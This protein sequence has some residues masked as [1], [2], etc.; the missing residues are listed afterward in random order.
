MK[1]RLFFPGFLTII[2]MTELI[3]PGFL[4]AAVEN[5]FSDD[6]NGTFFIDLS[7]TSAQIQNGRISLSGNSF[8][9]Q[10][11]SGVVLFTRDP[12]IEVFLSTNDSKI[13]PETRIIYY[14]STDEGRTWLQ[15]EPG[16][17][18]QFSTPGS[19]LK[20]KAVLSRQQSGVGSPFIESI[21]LIARSDSEILKRSRDQQR[22]SDLERV[23]TALE[24]FRTDWKTYPQVDAQS[25]EFRW[26]QLEQILTRQGFDGVSYIFNFPQDP[27][28]TDTKFKWSYDYDNIGS[29]RYVL[30]AKLEDF[31]ATY[32]GRTVL[33]GDLDEQIESVNCNDPIY[34]TGM[35]SQAQPQRENQGASIFNYFGSSQTQTSQTAQTQVQSSATSRTVR[36]DSPEE[37]RVA[38]VLANL[39]GN[40]PIFGPS[41]TQTSQ[42]RITQRSESEDFSAKSESATEGQSASLLSKIFSKRPRLVRENQTGNIYEIALGQRHWIPNQTVF[43]EYGFDQKKVE[44][45]SRAE[46]LVYPRAKLLR[47]DGDKENRIH[48]LTET[49]YTRPVPNMEVFQSYGDRIEDVIEI[50]QTEFLSYPKS[51]YV[52]IDPEDATAG[53]PLVKGKVW[54]IEGNTKRLVTTSVLKRLGIQKK[55]IGPINRTELDYYEEFEAIQ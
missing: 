6:F 52:A 7:Q 24:K 50:S 17:W 22:I 35:T 41:T 18:T 46:L 15:V 12:I 49:G 9:N 48:Y 40:L 10:V 21:N 30:A 2:L 47:V 20:W 55:E 28:R 27:L 45:V 37:K 54:Q 11:V 51:K 1:S 32:F 34:C 53:D 44:P 23:K 39:Y 14:L 13:P 5:T 31:N 38:A 42:T 33:V 19:R 43:K 36:F 26:K 25:D 16:S 29:D 4:R 8:S 3:L